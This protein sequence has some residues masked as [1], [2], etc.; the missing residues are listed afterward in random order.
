MCYTRV[1]KVDPPFA[2]FLPFADLFELA[3]VWERP[4]YILEPVDF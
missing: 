4:P 3:P 2:K 1:C